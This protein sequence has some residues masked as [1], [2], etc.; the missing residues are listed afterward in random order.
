[1]GALLLALA[2][3]YTPYHVYARSGLAKYLELERDLHTLQAHN[4]RL[5]SQIEKMS[6]EV[7]ALRD[8]PR[9]VE[10]VARHELGWVRPGDIV[11][12]FAGT[13]GEVSR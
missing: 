4:A 3:G 11:V 6:A 9:A 8:D 1:M 13:P 10:H 5:R 7:R 2:C 12:E